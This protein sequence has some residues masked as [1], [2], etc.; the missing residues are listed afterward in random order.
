MTDNSTAH[1]HHLIEGSRL[2]LRDLTVADVTDSYV[3]WMNDPE[4]VQ[5]TESRFS[6]HTHESIRAYVERITSDPAYVFL[7]IVLKDGNRHIGNIKLGP[8]DTQHRCGDVGIIIGE[9]DC[10]GE[11]YATEAIALLVDYA[12]SALSLRTVT[13]GCYSNNPASKKAFLKAGFSIDGVRKDYYTSNGEHVDSILLGIR[14][15]D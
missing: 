14:K 3:H 13:A 5:F 7:A 4:V 10:W 11:G 6:A 8:I 1:Y 15:P 12:F 9:K 2:F